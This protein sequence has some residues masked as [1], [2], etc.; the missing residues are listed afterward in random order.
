MAVHVISH[1]NQ[2][3]GA[4]E[5][6]PGPL[7]LV[8]IPTSLYI[9]T[10]YGTTNEFLIYYRDARS[11]K[12]C[13]LDFGNLI[14]SSEVEDNLGIDTGII[15]SFWGDMLM[16]DHIDINDIWADTVKSIKARFFYKDLQIPYHAFRATNTS[17]NLYQF[18]QKLEHCPGENAEALHDHLKQSKLKKKRNCD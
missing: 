14:S 2:I 15:P 10:V 12:S 3:E 1:L 11:D 8:V 7:P 5:G 4:Y 17:P 9:E 18:L 13:S 16:R 6:L